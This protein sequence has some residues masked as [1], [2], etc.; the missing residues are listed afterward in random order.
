MTVGSA[1]DVDFEALRARLQERLTSR[2]IHQLIRLGV[3]RVALDYAELSLEF[4]EDVDNGSGTIHGGIVAALADTAV[5]CAL[6]TNFDGKMGF[7]TSNLNIHFLRRAKTNVIAV[8]RI[9]K[10]GTTICVGSVEV[11]DEDEQ[12]VAT[13]TTDFVLTT[14][15]LPTRE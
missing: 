8:A 11:F 10:K 13:V 1:A 12:L 3:V 9:V 14:S 2:P 15:K 6:S 4:T 5:A 7:A